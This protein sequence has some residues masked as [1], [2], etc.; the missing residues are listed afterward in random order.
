MTN[1][2]EYN[3]WTDPQ[4]ADQVKKASWWNHEENK[5]FIE[6]PIALVQDGKHWV[7]STRRDERHD[8]LG[9]QTAVSQGETK[10]EAIKQLFF[11][12]RLRYDYCDEARLNYQRWVPFRKGPWGKTGGNWFSIFGFHVYFRYGKQNKGGYFIPFTW[13]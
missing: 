7:A 5:T 11:I 4:N 9:K 6:F 8:F 1:N 13:L 10:E 3:W 12:L 2:K